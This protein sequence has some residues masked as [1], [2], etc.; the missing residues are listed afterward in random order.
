MK[1]SLF[2]L[3]LFFTFILATTTVRASS[4]SE[5]EHGSELFK[6]N[7][8]VHCHTIN[9]AGGNKGPDLSS[10]GRTATPVAIRKQIV[11]GGKGMPPFGEILQPKE[12]D[13]LIAYLRSCTAKPKK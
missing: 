12:L 4:R 10:V 2:G 6:A 7:G 8:C 9:E 11:D 3:L 5:R 13:D 1:T